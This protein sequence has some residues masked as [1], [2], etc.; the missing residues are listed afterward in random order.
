MKHTDSGMK[1]PPSLLPGVGFSGTVLFIRRRCVGI[2]PGGGDSV[3]LSGISSS[4][5]EHSASF[6]FLPLGISDA[7]RCVFFINKKFN[8]IDPFDLAMA[9]AFFKS[10]SFE[11]GR[12]NAS[13]RENKHRITSSDANI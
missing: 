9:S 1:N 8:L 2:I 7:R 5:A 10:S 11:I 3:D 12:R 6:V 4:S 13:F